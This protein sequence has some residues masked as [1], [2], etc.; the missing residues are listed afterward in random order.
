MYQEC[1]IRFSAEEYS[2]D[3]IKN[4]FAHLTNNSVAKHS[5]KF[6]SDEIKGYM[7]FESELADVIKQQ[8]G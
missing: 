3:D 1:Y 4:R 7:F 2:P 6:E 8:T 5:E